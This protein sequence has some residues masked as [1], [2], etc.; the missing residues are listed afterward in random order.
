LINIHEVSKPYDKVLHTKDA[1][2]PG[3]KIQ[4]IYKTEEK[5]Q[6]PTLNQERN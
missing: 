2:Q 4:H 5:N 3:H 1:K 6:K